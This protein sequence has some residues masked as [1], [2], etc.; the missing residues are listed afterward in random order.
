[1]RVEK[2][3]TVFIDIEEKGFQ[4]RR[5]PR[6][7]TYSCARSTLGEAVGDLE[8]VIDYLRDLGFD[9]LAERAKEAFGIANFVYESLVARNEREIK[10]KGEK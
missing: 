2:G 6:G 1:M 8:V 7:L 4:P 10:D 3:E 9:D 5:D